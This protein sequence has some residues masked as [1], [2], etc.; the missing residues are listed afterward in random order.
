M[1]ERKL[2]VEAFANLLGDKPQRVKDVLR[3]KQRVPEDMLVALAHQGFDIAYLLTGLPR[4]A[5]A[6]LGVIKQASDLL[7]K[8]GAPKDVGTALLP[9]LVEVLS[10]GAITPNEGQLL[11]AFRKAS[12]SDQAV[13]QQ[14][15]ERFAA[16]A[17]PATPP[18]SSRKKAR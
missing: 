11:A 8:A 7:Q 17:P 4:A 15:A 16:H 6:R 5:H 1:E 14:M 12:P 10:D 13:I 9:A 3:G 2:T 18:V